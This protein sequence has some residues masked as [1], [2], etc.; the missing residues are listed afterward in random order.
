MIDQSGS[1]AND[2]SSSLNLGPVIEISSRKA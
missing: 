2:N 1:R